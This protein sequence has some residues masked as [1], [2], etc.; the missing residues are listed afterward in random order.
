VSA[1]TRAKTGKGRGATRRAAAKRQPN[2]AVRRA[3][4]RGGIHQ[5]HPSE[6]VLGPGNYL[7]MGL[8]LVA[9]VLGFI[10]LALKDITVSP[11]LLVLGYC[12]LIPA[13]LLQRGGLWR[14][15]SSKTGEDS[16]GE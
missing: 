11:I 10:L 9:I 1:A 5:D 16:G 7:L 8:G 6:L 3:L 14:R 2:P 4:R 12:I 13:G 15:V